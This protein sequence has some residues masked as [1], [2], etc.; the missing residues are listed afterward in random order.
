FQV[1]A[2]N[3]DGV[4]NQ[5]GD[6]LDFSIAPAYYQTNWFRALGALLLLFLAWG[7]YHLRIWQLHRHFEMTLDARVAERTRIARELHDTL[8][9][10][11]QALALRFQTALNVLPDRPAGAKGG[12]AAG[13]R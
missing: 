4:W 6:R 11:F 13:L 12:L 10:S 7:A 9:Q 5:Q 3:N 2:S 8:L 1:I